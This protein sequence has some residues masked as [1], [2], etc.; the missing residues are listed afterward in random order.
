MHKTLFQ[1]WLAC[2]VGNGGQS[3]QAIFEQINSHGVH[4][5]HQ[6]V[7]TQIVLVTV[8]Q[9]WF[10]HVLRHDIPT[11][12]ANLLLFANNADS[13]ATTCR[14]RLHNVHI[15]EISHFTINL[16][17]FVIFGENVRSRTNVEGL[18]VETPHSL[19]IT[20]HV[21]FAADWPT[22]CKMVNVL[23]RTDILQ[24][25]LAEKASPHD[26]VRSVRNVSKTSHF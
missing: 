5:G 19:H 13:F 16:P 7:Q 20:P 12:F 26:I 8:Y 1:T 4:G 18:P 15:F 14:Y 25:T 22:A 21:I 3:Y 2:W 11:S 9:V 10:R 17:S 6:N 23:H 24:T